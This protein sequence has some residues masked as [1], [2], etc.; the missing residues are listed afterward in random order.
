MENFQSHKDTMVEFDEKGFNAIVGE[1]DKGKSSII[2]AIKWCLYNDPQGTDMIRTGENYCLVALTFSNGY[3]VVRS[4]DRKGA[5]NYEVYHVATK[6]SN[7]YKGFGRNIPIEVTNAHQIP[8]GISIA[9]QL[10]GPYMLSNTA[11]ERAAMIGSIVGTDIVD[12][13]IKD[14]SSEITVT[15]RVAKAFGEAV[16][17]HKHE[18]TAY[19]NLDAEID[20]MAK[21]NAILTF[22]QVVE[23]DKVAVED[24][25]TRYGQADY[26]R[27]QAEYYLSFYKDIDKAEALINNAQL[28]EAERMSLGA[29]TQQHADASHKVRALSSELLFYDGL[30]A[31][32]VSIG[33]IDN[34]SAEY[35]TLLNTY[36]VYQTV[37]NMISRLGA[38]MTLYA[39]LDHIDMTHVEQ[40][41]QELAE[42]ER[43]HRAWVQADTAVILCEQD[44]ASCEDP[45][46]IATEYQNLLVQL[47]KCPTCGTVIDSVAGKYIEM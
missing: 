4:R 15:Q 28:I 37:D 45:D 3:Q 11:P 25:L 18:L 6:K 7:V 46:D 24:L 36:N 34:A 44:L 14:V 9:D 5:G 29:I 22:A 12:A 47:G 21:I 17:K 40:L 23:K 31:A 42:L 38:E 19:D 27:G 10:E 43:I 1:T 33:I 2:R 39:N 41:Q 8:K 35:M 32:A 16:D 13:A 30:P 20:H 26:D